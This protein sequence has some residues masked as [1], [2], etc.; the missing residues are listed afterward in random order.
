[1]VVMGGS[2]VKRAE[3][4][5]WRADRKLQQDPRQQQIAR[6]ESNDIHGVAKEDSASDDIGA[7]Q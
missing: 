7:R 5:E 6:R 2:W 1:M 4:D 3:S